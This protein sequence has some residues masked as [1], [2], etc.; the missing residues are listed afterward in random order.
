[1]EME[2]VAL[3]IG[4]V[5]KMRFTQ[6]FSNQG[7]CEMIEKNFTRVKKPIFM[8]IIGAH[9]SEAHTSKSRKLCRILVHLN[10]ARSLKFLLHL[11]PCYI[12]FKPPSLRIHIRS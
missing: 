12:A 8:A 11:R 3:V 9:S 2:E 10:V 5:S 6:S 4:Q 1:M 7:Y